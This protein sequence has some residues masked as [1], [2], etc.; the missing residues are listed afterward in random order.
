[1][2]RARRGEQRSARLSRVSIAHVDARALVARLKQVN[3]AA[4]G[5]AQ[6]RGRAPV[7][8]DGGA[9]QR[10]DAPRAQ[11][12]EPRVELGRVKAQARLEARFVQAEHEA[13]ARDSL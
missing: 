2:R 12:L 10:I 9:G 8:R 4:A 6:R 3:R 5:A 7:L 11:V 13:V 1:A